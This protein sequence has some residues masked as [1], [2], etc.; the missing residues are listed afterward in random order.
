MAIRYPYDALL[1]VAVKPPEGVHAAKRSAWTRFGVPEKEVEE[2]ALAHGVHPFEAWPELG[3]VE[4]EECKAHGCDEPAEWRRQ[5]YCSKRR[6]IC[7]AKDCTNRFHPKN[8]NQRFC[9]KACSR[10]VAMRAYRA[11]DKGK[12]A[13]RRTKEKYRTECGDY[14]KK[15]NERYRADTR[16]LR[17]AKRRDYYRRN[18]ARLLEEKREYH[19]ANRERRNALQAGYYRQNVEKR[20]AYQRD[21]YRRNKDAIRMKQAERR[22]RQIDGYISVRELEES[23]LGPWWL[24]LIHVEALC[25]ESGVEPRGTLTGAEVAGVR[26]QWRLKLD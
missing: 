22:S 12:A 17:L 15:Y 8:T 20:K 23:Y 16:E 6:L 11:T 19:K 21:Y 18:R 14:I 10:R 1:R 4:I 5:G 25:K 3:D 24:M 7:A 9:R 13:E 26:L 2:A